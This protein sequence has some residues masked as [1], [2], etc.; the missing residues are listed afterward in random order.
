MEDPL[1]GIGFLQFVIG[2]VLILVALA[3]QL[4]RGGFRLL[5]G[6]ERWER[7]LDMEWVQMRC[8]TTD[9]E[10]SCVRTELKGLELCGRPDPRGC[11]AFRQWENE[12]FLTEWKERAFERLNQHWPD[13]VTRLRRL[14]LA[15]EWLAYLALRFEQLSAA[16]WLSSGSD[17]N[18][19]PPDG[20]YVW[21]D[22]LRHELHNDAW[23][24]SS[25]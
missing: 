2:G 14:G 3:Y 23:L 5:V 1:A 10:D 7:H 12:K 24:P 16:P 21:V 13:E 25:R 15:D 4:G 18:S 11:D 8:G 19:P 9:K 22:L 17:S 6:H 20:W